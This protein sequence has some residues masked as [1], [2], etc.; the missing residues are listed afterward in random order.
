MAYEP[1]TFPPGRTNVA[2]EINFGFTLVFGATALSSVKGK[3]VTGVRNSAGQ[4]KF[5]FPKTYRKRTGFQWGWG[6][7]AAGIVLFPVILTDNLAVD[8]T[9]TVETRTEAGV[10]TDPAS[11]NELDL[12][13]SATMNVL[14]DP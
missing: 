12:V 7:C 13:V 1:N 5:T 9:V 6:K 3:H 4:Y 2:D 8:G 14:N 10:A 11:G